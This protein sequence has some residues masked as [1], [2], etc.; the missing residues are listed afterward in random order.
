KID[1]LRDSDEEDVQQHE[2]RFDDFRE[3]DH[4]LEMR[5]AARDA[6]KADKDS[7]DQA[8]SQHTDRNRDSGHLTGSELQRLSDDELNE[9]AE[10][11]PDAP[12]VEREKALRSAKAR[13]DAARRERDAAAERDNE[14]TPQKETPT[15]EREVREDRGTL[16]DDL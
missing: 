1:A 7:R 8:E 10:K 6:Q 15:D 3:R 12:G 16:L 2:A 4:L 14:T 5:S 11:N 13:R 9:Y